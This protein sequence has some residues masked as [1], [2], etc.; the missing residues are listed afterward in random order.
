MKNE[1][2]MSGNEVGVF[3]RIATTAL[4]VLTAAIPYFIFQLAI[5]NPLPEW[6][7]IPTVFRDMAGYW[8]AHEPKEM[9]SPKFNNLFWIMTC[10][11]SVIIGFYIG[12]LTKKAAKTDAFERYVKK[13]ILKVLDV[14]SMKLC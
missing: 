3:G 7:N 8:F 2:T 12:L 1:I 13:P 4:L 10:V 11:E 6:N 14:L 9:L 5:E